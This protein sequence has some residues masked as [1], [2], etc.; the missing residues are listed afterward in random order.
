MCTGHSHILR[1]FPLL[2]RHRSIHSL[3]V[4]GGV[5][6]LSLA[7]VRP[8]AAP[9]PSEALG[10]TPS[11]GC[12]C[13]LVC[14]HFSHLQTVP[15]HFLLPRPLTFSCGVQS[16]SSN[17]TFG[18]LEPAWVLQ[19]NLPSQGSYLHHI[20]SLCGRRRQSFCLKGSRGW[21]LGLFGEAVIQHHRRRGWD[22]PKNAW[23]FSIEHTL[24]SSLHLFPT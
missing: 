14:S 4:P 22:I 2:K 9:A 17:D 19:D 13:S 21:D 24:L 16:P 10:E 8:S 23:S 1:V 11:S 6:S 20:R 7:T 15:P 3:A 5:K 18:S 12:S